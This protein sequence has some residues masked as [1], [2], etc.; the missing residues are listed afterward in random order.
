LNKD[1]PEYEPIKQPLNK[2]ELNIIG[3]N[4]KK[5]TSNFAPEKS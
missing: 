4:N 2:V 3:V 1:L 5:P